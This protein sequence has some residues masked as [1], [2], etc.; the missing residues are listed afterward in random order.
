MTPK[1]IAALM[2]DTIDSKAALVAQLSQC[3]SDAKRVQKGLRHAM[4]TIE[5]GSDANVRKMLRVTMKSVAEQAETLNNLTVLSLISLL[6][7]DYDSNVAKTL[8]VLLPD[9]GENILQGMLA[10]K[11][12]GKG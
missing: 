8:L 9:E 7:P 2:N 12:A 1:Q 6:S 4:V 10:R 11:M 3:I 5:T